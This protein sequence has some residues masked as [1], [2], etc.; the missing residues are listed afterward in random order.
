MCEVEIKAAKDLKSHLS[1]SVCKSWP[2]AEDDFTELDAELITKTGHPAPT[3]FL[4]DLFEQAEVTLPGGEKV[5][6]YLPIGSSKRLGDGKEAYV[7]PMKRRSDRVIVDSSLELALRSHAY[8]SLVDIK[9]YKVSYNH[10]YK[11]TLRPCIKQ[12]PLFVSL[13]HL[14]YYNI[15]NNPW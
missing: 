8:C 11:S 14:S 3:P 2:Q 15:N 6:A 10:V 13:F 7:R 1:V 4:N 12:I 9:D 5:Y